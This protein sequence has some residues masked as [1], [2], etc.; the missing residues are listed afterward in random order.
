MMFLPGESQGLG[1]AWWAAVYGVTQSWTWLKRLSSSSSS[2]TGNRVQIFA[3]SPYKKLCSWL[4]NL[5]RVPG[6]LP[7]AWGKSQVIG[8]PSRWSRDTFSSVLFS[9]SIVSD[10]LWP[11]GLPVKASLSITNSW[12]LLKL[13]SIKSVM[14]SRQLILCCPLL[15]PP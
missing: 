15:L 9:H 4:I 2:S 10:C 14:P 1:G 3:N 5:A 7:G 13:M 6:P 8:W 11:Q 12:S